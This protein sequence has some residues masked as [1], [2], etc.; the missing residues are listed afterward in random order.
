MRFWSL[1]FGVFLATTIMGLRGPA[2][3]SAEVRILE[4]ELAHRPLPPPGPKYAHGVPER[5][6]GMS[7]KSRRAWVAYIAQLGPLGIL[8]PVDGFALARLCEDVAHLQELQKGQRK[9]ARQHKKSMVE[10]AMSQEGRRLSATINAIAQRIKRDELQFGLT[11]VSS[12]RLADYFAPGAMPRA[13]GS[14]QMHDPAEA[15]IG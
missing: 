1:F 9:Y 13:A 15:A 5:P 6:V 3:K 12:V 2:P 10:F 8:R 14:E 7:A 4:G 11:P